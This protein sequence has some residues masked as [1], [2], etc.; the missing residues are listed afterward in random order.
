[1]RKLI[2]ISEKEVFEAAWLYY[3][4]LW[5]SAKERAEFAENTLGRKSEILEK[6]VIEYKAIENELHDCLLKLE[7]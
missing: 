7:K 1:M 5:S 6:R 3:L 4:D 2:T